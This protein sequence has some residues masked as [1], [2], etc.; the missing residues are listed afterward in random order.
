MPNI[1]MPRAVS[2]VKM[3]RSMKNW[4]MFIRRLLSTPRAGRL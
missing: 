2:V 4:E 1:S 3:G